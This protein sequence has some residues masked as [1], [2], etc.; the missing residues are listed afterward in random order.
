MKQTKDERKSQFGLKFQEAKDEALSSLIKIEI[1]LSD[2][3]IWWESPLACRW[4]PWEESDEFQ[5][6]DP[7]IQDYNINHEKYIKREQEKLFKVAEIKKKKKIELNDFQLAPFSE[8]IKLSTLIEKYLAPLI[9]CDFPLHIDEIDY[10]EKKQ[11]AWKKYVDNLRAKRYRSEE[12]GKFLLLDE[13]ME[14]FVKK[15]LPPRNLFPIEYCKKI[16]VL[17]NLTE[18]LFVEI[19][20]EELK[21]YNKPELNININEDYPIKNEPIMLSDFI[22]KIEEY[23]KKLQP[24]F[25]EDKVEIFLDN[26]DQKKKKKKMEV[27]ESTK[28][29]KDVELILIPHEKGKWSTR[30]IYEQ[31]YDAES[32]ILTFYAGRM[33]NFGIATKKFINLPLKTWEL[34]P[35]NE[36]IVTLRIEAQN[37]S[38]EFQITEEGYTFKIIKPLKAPIQEIKKPLRVFELKKVDKFV[39]TAVFYHYSL[40]LNFI[41]SLIFSKFSC[42]SVTLNDNDHYY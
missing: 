8:N 21:M 14:K 33:G 6:F 23:Q 31:S 35:V 24:N 1:K 32:K 37:I 11:K 22:A 28:V 2:K 42:D 17:E 19:K 29:E 25:V 13:F 34:F 5:Q 18:K 39:I 3:I 9:P 4:E 27:D 41:L 16:K 7:K 36:K 26:K 12:I 38:I 40:S 20:R 15:N 30:D 10:Y